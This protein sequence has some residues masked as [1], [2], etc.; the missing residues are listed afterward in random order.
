[1]TN[2]DAS[3]APLWN[4]GGVGLLS[5]VLVCSLAW[6]LGENLHYKMLWEKSLLFSLLGICICEKHQGCEVWSKSRA[7]S[8]Y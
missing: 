8:S 6:S 2:R 1:M 5:Q 7:A 4:K 3:L